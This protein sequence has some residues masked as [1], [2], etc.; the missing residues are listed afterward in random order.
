MEQN[1]KTKI[2]SRYHDPLDHR[3]NVKAT[4]GCRHSNPEICG[5]NALQGKCAFV[6]EDNICMV[7]PSTW[8]RQFEKLTLKNQR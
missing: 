2:K 7:P 4:Y 1:D 6:R 8:K 3:D 5:N